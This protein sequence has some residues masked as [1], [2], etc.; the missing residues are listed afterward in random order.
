MKDHMKCAVFYGK[1]DLRI[2]DR[3]IP[4]IEENDVLIK[5]AFC[6]ICGSDIHI[7]KGEVPWP[8][9]LILG[10]EYSGEIVDVGK[11]VKEL[12]QGDKV[13]VAPGIVCHKCFFCRRGQEHL[14]IN[15]RLTDGG[16]AEFV[17]VPSELV[18]ILPS[19][20]SYEVG[21]L[22]EPLGC[23]LHAIE[24][25]SISPGDKV[26]IT[27]A[28]PI[29]LMLI[30][31]AKYSG[32]SLIILSEPHKLRRSLAR[33]FGADIVVDPMK[34]NLLETIEHTTQGLGVD[35]CIEA[36]GFPEPIKDC[37]KA[38]RRGGRVVLM[39]V[40]PRFTEIGIRPYEVYQK[41]LT[42]KAS[43]MR[44]FS[45]PKAVDLLPKLSLEPLITHHYP[46]RNIH[47]ALEFHQSRE[48][49]KILIDPKG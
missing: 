16:F 22:A 34:E 36:T 31:C 45:F 1:N 39:G 47:Q 20:I 23:C 15:R 17:S 46:L 12:K 11:K 40:T 27:G 10:H 5:V 32:S 13:T 44:G 43:F 4:L 38:V 37:I 48:G 49:V 29:G 14:C 6:G 42:L 28:G 26:L 3:P 9:P 19:D 2:E 33:K 21:T 24:L 7:L 25:A 18:Y 8:S 30:K 35:V 41:E